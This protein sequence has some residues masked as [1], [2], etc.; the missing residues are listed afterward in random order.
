[1]SAWH[2]PRHRVN[3]RNQLNENCALRMSGCWLSD[4]KS[5][6]LTNCEVFPSCYVRNVNKILLSA[7]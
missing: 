1:M 3:W 6:E 2:S 4:F 7:F 5:Y